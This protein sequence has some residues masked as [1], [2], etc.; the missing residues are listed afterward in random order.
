MILEPE[1]EFQIIGEDK[2]IQDLQGRGERERSVLGR[3][4]VN[5]NDLAEPSLWKNKGYVRLEGAEG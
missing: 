4:N 1:H 5:D 3:G 2:V